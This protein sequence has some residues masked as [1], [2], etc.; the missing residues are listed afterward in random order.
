MDSKDQPSRVGWVQIPLRL[1]ITEPSPEFL[2]W[3]STKVRRVTAESYTKRIKQ[4]GKLGDIE[5]PEKIRTILCTYPASEARKELL[6]NAY[7]YYCEFRGYQWIK[8]RF[9]REDQAF[10]LPT[11][12]ELNSLI[13]HTSTKLSTFL[14]LLKETGVSSGE[15][16][17]LKWIDV[18]QYRQT[19]DITPT[20]NHNARVLPISTNLLSRLVRLPQENSRIFANKDLD[21]FRWRYERKRNVL[22]VKLENPRIHQI[23]FKSFRHWKATMEYYKTKDILHVQY[24]LGHKRLSNTLIYTH[25]VNFES[26]EFSC[27]TAHTLEEACSLIEAGFDYVTEMDGFKLFKK[28]K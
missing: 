9:T 18:N 23:A 21:K 17:K 24:I 6:T 19:V 28:R 27:K 1:P 15:A 7:D 2:E 26:D 20:K 4:L 22:A 11:E 25:L 10:F 8:P 13:A 14:Q 3:L 12:N 5:Q 16:W